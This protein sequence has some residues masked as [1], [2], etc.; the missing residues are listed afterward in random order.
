MGGIV[1]G[2]FYSFNKGLLGRTVKKENCAKEI[3]ESRGGF[4][5]NSRGRRR[6]GVTLDDMTRELRTI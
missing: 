2:L 1:T 3:M 4:S 5:V 6:R